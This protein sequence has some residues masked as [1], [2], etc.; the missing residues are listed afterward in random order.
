V[1]PASWLGAALVLSAGMHLGLYAL[2]RGHRAAPA[3]LAAAAV[4]V[5]VWAPL[6]PVLRPA[7]SK[8][9]SLTPHPGPPARAER[10]RT[11]ASARPLVPAPAAEAGL[12][13]PAS[14]GPQD[15]DDRPSGD[16][17]APASRAGGTGEGAEGSEG[18]GSPGLL[19]LSQRLAEA[20]RACY[21]PAA[22]RLR[23]V[24]SVELLFCAEPDGSA[25]RVSLAGSTGSVLLDRAAEDCLLARIA[26]LPVRE[27]CFRLPVRFGEAVR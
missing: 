7:P 22:R 27:G 10:S 3:D 21:P 25:S 14:E 2:M 20:A 17:A 24:G 4:K 5:E 16:A 19:A 12:E 1:K 26:P 6:P 9:A 18:A 11:R 15:A 8:E 13:A 23:L